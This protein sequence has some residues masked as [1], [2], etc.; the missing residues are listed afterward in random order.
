MEEEI[1]AGA[2]DKIILSKLLPPST[3]FEHFV[4]ANISLD[5]RKMNL[6]HNW[7]RANTRFILKK[8]H[9]LSLCRPQTIRKSRDGDFKS[10]E[11]FLKSK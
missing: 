8:G 9:F 3:Y 1:F 11:Y 10:F 6:S 7:S 2:I 5:F 4:T